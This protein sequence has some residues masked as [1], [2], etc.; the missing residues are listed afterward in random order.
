MDVKDL[1]LK[2]RADTGGKKDKKPEGKY[3]PGAWDKAAQM[4]ERAPKK[5]KRGKK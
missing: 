3:P 4:L 5:K 1:T 2:I